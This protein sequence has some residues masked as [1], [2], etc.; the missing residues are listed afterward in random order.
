MWR[1]DLRNETFRYNNN[2][3]YSLWVY[4]DMWTPLLACRVPEA[5]EDRQES[6]ALS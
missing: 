2:V 1:N 4:P 3:Q 6:G 5:T